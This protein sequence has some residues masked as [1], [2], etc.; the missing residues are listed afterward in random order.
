M[1]AATPNP[2]SPI[3]RPMTPEDLPAVDRVAD[4]IHPRFPED[5]AV[6]AERL[7]LYPEGCRVLERGDELLGYVVSHPWFYAR[8]PALNSLLGALPA[9]AETYYIHDIALL[10]ESQGGGAAGRIVEA[11]AAHAWARDFPNISL[12]AVNGSVPFWARRGFHI[13][14]VPEIESKLRGYEDAARFMVREILDPP[15]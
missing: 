5:P 12:I 15:P 8:P 2:A 7:A 3:W 1:D 6:F 4:I 11:L 9:V 14:A 13:V 10:P